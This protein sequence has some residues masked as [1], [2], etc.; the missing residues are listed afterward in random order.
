M[1]WLVSPQE[2]EQPSEIIRGVIYRVI[3]GVAFLPLW[4]CSKIYRVLP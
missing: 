1:Y 2:E 4:C 3:D